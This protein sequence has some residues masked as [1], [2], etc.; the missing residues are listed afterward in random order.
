MFISCEGRVADT[1]YEMPFLGHRVYSLEELCYVIYNNIYSIN[2]EFFQ[3][4]LAKWLR[5][6]TDHHELADKL[7]NLL[8]EEPKLKD[9]VVT[10]LCGCDYYKEKE[11]RQ[12]IQ[13]MDGIANL[14]LYQ[15]KKIKADNYL[16]AGS[17]G[18]SLVEYRKLLSGSFAVNFTTEEYGDLLHNQ[19]IAHFYTSS[20]SEAEQDFKEAFVRNNK[21]A[22]LQHYLWVLLMQEKQQ[23]FE[24][25][26]ISFG[27]SPEEARVT[28]LKYKEAVSQCR[29]PEAEEDDILRYKEQLIQ[30]TAC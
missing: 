5:H 9:L 6:E 29:I 2:A 17:Y 30:A 18:K 19:G 27:M 20:F 24:A 15:K 4:S 22:S 23:L 12:L 14:P 13:V 21:K 11:I 26:A 7:E 8:E 28:E 1:P 16:R 25:E 3:L 10:I